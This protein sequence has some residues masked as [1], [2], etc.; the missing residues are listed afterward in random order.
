[1]KIIIQTFLIVVA[2][3]IV[4]YL[5]FSSAGRLLAPGTH[6]N[7]NNKVCFSEKCFSVEVAKTDAEKEKGLMNRVALGKDIG[8]FF[9]FDKEGIYPFWMKNTLIP[10]DIIWINASNKVVFIASDIQPCKSIICPL[11]TPTGQ[12]KYVL[13]LNSNVSKSIRLKVGDIA[14]IIIK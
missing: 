10:L 7:A 13:E 14:E 5:L 6:Q 11:I 4:A 12:A 8:M 3:I 2:A 1:M 9:I